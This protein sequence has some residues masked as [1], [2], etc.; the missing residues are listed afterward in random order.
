MNHR[1][2]SIAVACLVSALTPLSLI[3]QAKPAAPTTSAPAAPAK[4][5][6]SVKGEATVDYI[7]GKPV[8]AKGAI[9]TKMQVKNTSKGAIALL[10]VEEYWYNNKSEIASL[11]TYRNRALLNPGDVLEFTISTQ[12]KPGLYTNMLMFKHAN[13]TIKPTKVTKFK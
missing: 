5:I 11:G 2:A 8:K 13:G 9:M 4:F 7:Q 3:A 1:F 6:P 10:S 12:D